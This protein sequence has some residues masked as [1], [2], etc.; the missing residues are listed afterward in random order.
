[1]T[2]PSAVSPPESAA[3]SEP[4]AAGRRQ[5]RAVDNGSSVPC[6]RSSYLARRRRALQRR[7]RSLWLHQNRRS[8]P[9]HL[10]CLRLQPRAI[11]RAPAAAATGGCD[12]QERQRAI[13]TAFAFR[14]FVY[15][16]TGSSRRECSWLP[17]KASDASL[18]EVAQTSSP[19][20]QTATSS[21]MQQQR[22]PGSDGN[23][24]AGDSSA[25]VGA[26]V[27]RV[28]TV[29]NN[30]ESFGFASGYAGKAGM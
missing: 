2:P 11:L 23:A 12:E 21:E 3:P 13:G 26:P 10:G 22:I 27:L 16:D 9:I 1:M 19:K 28:E 15:T 4:P 8:R 24:T 5:R 29:I 7:L 18:V 20:V 25:T 6:L 14:R 30:P 17:S